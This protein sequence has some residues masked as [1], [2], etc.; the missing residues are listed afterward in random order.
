MTCVAGPTYCSFEWQSIEFLPVILIGQGQF[1]LK[2]ISWT[3]SGGTSE[4]CTTLVQIQPS[5]SQFSQMYHIDK[6]C[7]QGEDLKRPLLVA[8]YGWNKSCYWFASTFFSIRMKFE[9]QLQQL[10]VQH[11]SLSSMFVSC[12]EFIKYLVEYV[13]SCLCERGSLCL[14]NVLVRH[15]RDSQ[16]RSSLQRMLHLSS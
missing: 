3:E 16:Q 7:R 11:K 8:C 1:S 15:P 13:G 9:N 10:M 4:L 14:L 12:L 2:S 6:M 5:F